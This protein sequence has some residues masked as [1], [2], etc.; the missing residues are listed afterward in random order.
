MTM[1]IEFE[2]DDGSRAKY[3][4][5]T[6]QDAWDLVALVDPV[7]RE[8]KSAWRDGEPWFGLCTD[9]REGTP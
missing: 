9:M 4:A 7:G 3:T 2:W 5:E 1:S 6:Y 8:I